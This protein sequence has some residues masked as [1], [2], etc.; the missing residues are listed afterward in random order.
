MAAALRNAALATLLAATPSDALSLKPSAAEDS[1]VWPFGNFNPFGSKGPTKSASGV[2]RQTLANLAD[3]QYTGEIL[4]GGQKIKAIID[5]G[6]F[7]LLAFG[8]NCSACGSKPNLYDASASK[9]HIAGNFP[10]VHS[11]GSGTCYAMEGSDSLQ[12]GPLKIAQQTFWEVYDA[13]MPILAEDSFHA[14]FGVGPPESAVAFAKAV[15][16]EVHGDLDE[17][18]RKGKTITEDIHETVQ[19]Y[20][21]AVEHAAKVTSVAQH[22]YLANIS[23]CLGRES[24]SPGYFNWNDTATADQPDKFTE[25]KV[26]GD[27]YWSAELTDV[28]VGHQSKGA[29]GKAVCSAVIDTGTS[30][31]AA[32]SHFVEEIYE[33]VET[34]SMEGGSCDDVSGLPDLEFKMDGKIFSLPPSA[35]VGSVQYDDSYLNSDAVKKF[36]PH[37]KREKRQN[38]RVGG[39]NTAK[40]QDCEVLLITM[41][42]DSQF[43]PLWILGL[44][45][46]REYYTSFQFVTK[47]GGRPQARTM[48][49]S[50]ADD[51]CNPGAA[52]REQ[53]SELLAK[54][55]SSKATLKVKPSQI[56]LP[57]W[58]RSVQ[59]LSELTETNSSGERSPFRRAFFRI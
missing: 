6:S 59:K 40:K 2:Y 38:L 34:W 41:D 26:V 14:I 27:I 1:A 21:D 18:K 43:G 28:Q 16:T 55:S 51:K 29:C 4:V 3:V 44:P 32:P 42:A 35:Y 54:V 24:G 58:A 57:R 46:F 20:D 45:L 19:Y 30:L 49:L 36:L 39:N 23:E 47:D 48:S 37:L 25:I 50:V 33:L 9:R 31:I 52:N 11:Y 22:L 12:I 8:S 13:N 17:Y 15:A 5:T 10:G 56:I 7:E 53:A